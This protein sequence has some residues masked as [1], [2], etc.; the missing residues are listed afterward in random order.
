MRKITIIDD[1]PLR[2][3][4][5]LGEENVGKLKSMEAVKTSSFLPNSLTEWDDFDIIAVHRSLLQEKSMYSETVEYAEK[6]NKYLVIFSGGTSHT[7]LINDHF[8]ELK[9][10]DFYNYSRLSAF[11]SKVSTTS[12]KIELLELLYGEK[13]IL[14]YLVKY[15]HLCWQHPESTRNDDTDNRIYDLG[16]IINNYFGVEDCNEEFVKNKIAELTQSI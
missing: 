9:A 6:A 11:I 7:S 15:Q 10:V 12:E 8:L 13:W 14:S 5:L 1:R 3:A 2:Q 16:D 4:S